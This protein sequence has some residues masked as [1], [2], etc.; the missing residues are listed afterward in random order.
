MK[1][2]IDT[3]DSLKT[4]LHCQRLLEKAKIPIV[5]HQGNFT[6]L[7]E[8]E[9]VDRYNDM[10]ALHM[11]LYSEGDPDDVLAFLQAEKERLSKLEVL[12]YM[13]S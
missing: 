13:H 10:K 7:T 5:T 6:C 3:V 12:K 2:A 8:A 11:L 1:L 4:G 9:R